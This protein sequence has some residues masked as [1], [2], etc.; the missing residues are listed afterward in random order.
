MPRRIPDTA[1]HQT[2]R[3][4]RLQAPPPFRSFAVRS[5]EARH[6]MQARAPYDRVHLVRHC[7][8]DPVNRV[9]PES[10]R[11]LAVAALP[12]MTLECFAD[13]DCAPTSL[14]EIAAIAPDWPD[15]AGALATALES[16]GVFGDETGAC[17]RSV[18]ARV[19]FLGC[20]GAGFHND[21]ADHWSRCLFWL[22]ALDLEDVEF[23]MPHAG[24]RVRLACG[25]L[26]VF[27]PALAHGLCRPRDGGKA[28]EASFAAGDPQVF[29]TGELLLDD[30]RWAALGAPWLAVEEHERRG[31]LDLLVAEFD[32]RSGAIKRPHALRDGMKRSTCHVDESAL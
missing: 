22:L 12:R 2:V 5:D 19:D 27:D 3:L 4:E 29:L 6:A 32:D 23:V 30:V 14:S 18:E 25:D 24:L 28:L 7:H 1:A 17:R 13:V 11:R 26:L 8:V 21:V 16:T 9:D 15:P 20:R 31:A 10:L